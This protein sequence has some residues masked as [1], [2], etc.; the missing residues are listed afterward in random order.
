M[1]FERRDELKSSILKFL[2]MANNGALLVS[3]IFISSIYQAAGFAPIGFG[4]IILTIGIIYYS[5]NLGDSF[6]VVVFEKNNTEEL[7]HLPCLIIKLV[8][9]TFECCRCEYIDIKEKITYYDGHVEER[10]YCTSIFCFVWNFLCLIIKLMST[11]FTIISYY[12]FLGFFLL[13]RL[14]VRLTCYNYCIKKTESNENNIN[15]VQV[16]NN[17]NDANVNLNP[18]IE[19]NENLSN[20]I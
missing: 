6:T 14:I 15:E 2:F 7:C 18:N 16:N 10:T 4:I 19:S 8:R 3:I 17:I 5:C 11:F 9:F 13:V 20:T 12:I 1:S